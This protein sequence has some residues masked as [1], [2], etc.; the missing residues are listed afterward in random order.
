MPEPPFEKQ[1]LLL[2]VLLL[3]SVTSMPVPLFQEQVLFLSVFLS[4]RDW[5]RMPHIL[6]EV[7]VLFISE[8]LDDERDMPAPLY[9]QVLLISVL[10]PPPLRPIPNWFEKQVLF[11]IMILL[12]RVR[13]IPYSLA[14]QLLFSKVPLAQDAR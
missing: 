10:P 5:T 6:F 3:D 2:T 12:E 8:F 1:V 9:R 7:Q 13:Y 4:P 11:L 14:E